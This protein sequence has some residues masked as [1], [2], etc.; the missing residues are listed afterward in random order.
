MTSALLQLRSAKTLF[1][2]Q[3][4]F[5]LLAWCTAL[6]VG[7]WVVADL[8]WRLTA[9]RPSLTLAIAE[10]DPATAAGRIAERHLFGISSASSNAEDGERIVLF[11]AVT[12]EG[13][14]PGFAILS[15]DGGPAKDAVAG[16]ELAP[17][18]VLSRIGPD[19][20]ELSGASGTRTVLLQ[21]M[22]TGSDAT[23][24]SA[25]GAIPATGTLPAP[26]TDT[27]RSIE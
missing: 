10:R 23:S 13:R 16:Q 18:L 27:T 17:G 21:T 7:A 26:A 19:R 15:I 6:G 1:A 4:H 3:R 11:G 12:G 22:R 9:P 14:H 5:A 24:G 20:I 8:F 2:W 25:R